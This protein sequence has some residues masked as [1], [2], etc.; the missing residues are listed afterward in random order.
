MLGHL[1]LHRNEVVGSERLIDELWGESPPPT[2]AKILQN[3]VSHLRRALGANGSDGPLETR[4]RGYRLRVEPLA[5]DLERFERPRLDPQPI[6]PPVGL[7]RPVAAARTQRAAQMRDVVLQDLPGRRRRTP[8]P[9][10]VDQPLARDDLV[11][12]QQQIP[13]HRPLAIAAHS[14]RAVAIGH[15]QR[16]ENSVVH[17]LLGATLPRARPTAGPLE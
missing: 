14:D 8:A 16:P 15:L 6:T 11:A 2:A 12:M 1:L 4:G 10:L 3:Y 13:E 17:A 5:L 7:R 9:Q